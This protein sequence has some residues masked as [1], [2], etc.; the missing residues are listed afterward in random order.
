MVIKY[1]YLYTRIAAKQCYKIF[2]LGLANP[3]DGPDND[4]GNGYVTIEEPIVPDTCLPVP[5]NYIK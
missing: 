2:A 5:G 4:V 1:R 3:K